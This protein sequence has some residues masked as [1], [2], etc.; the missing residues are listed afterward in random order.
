MQIDKIINNIK[1]LYKN[2][3]EKDFIYQFIESL[4]FYP[5]NTIARLKGD[6]N[7]SNKP[8]ELIWKDKI[9]FVNCKNTETDAHILADELKKDKTISKNKIRFLII[10]NFD[11]F[12]SIDI[13]T[14]QS[15]ECKF[16]ELHKFIDFFLPLIGIEKFS[17][18]EESEADIKA[19]NNL[20]KLYD[21]ILIDN[22][23]FDLKKNRHSLNFFFIRLL[24]LYYADDSKVFQ[25]NLFLK[26]ISDL[27]S[28]DGS[29]LKNFFYNLFDVLKTKESK[30]KSDYFEKFPYVNGF[31]FSADI[32]LPNFT[33]KTREMIISNASLDWQNINPDIFGSMLQ[34][35]VSPEE[36]EGEEMHYTSIPNI[37]KSLD[38]L[39]LNKLKEKVNEANNDNKKLKKI[40]KYIYNL[41]IF[42]PACGSGNFL[43]VAYKN[44]CLI[45]IDI[46]KKLKEIEPDEWLLAMPGIK[47]S[48]F[49]GIEKSHFA[50]ETA[51]LSIW[52]AQHQMNI[53]YKE[54]FDVIK[55][56]LPIND[57][58]NIICANSITYEWK[59]FFLKDPIESKIYILGNPPFKAKSKRNKAQQDDIK[60]YFG[61]TRNI[62]YVAL[63]FLKACDFA[64]Y[65]IETKIGFVATNS[66]NQ[67]EQVELLW[68]GILKRN[69]HIFFAYKSFKW[70][71][72][73]KKNA[74]VTVSIICLSKKKNDQKILVIDEQSFNV[75]NINPYLISAP[76]LIIKKTKQNLFS[77]P[78]MTIGEMPR[79]NGHLLLDLKDK[80]EILTKHPEAEK[81]IK[82]F[83]GGKE[84]INNLKR[85][86][87]WINDKQ[88]KEAENFFLI[89]KR[90]E[91]VKKFRNSSSNLTTVAYANKAYRFVEIRKQEKE[92]FFLP[93]TSSADR[94]YVPVGYAEK[95]IIFSNSIKIIYSPP[96]YIFA[97][98][99]SKMHNVW[100]KN[101]GGKLRNDIRYS[102]EII[103]NNFPVPTIDDNM[104][105][106]LTDL[107]YEL[108]DLRDKFFDKS[109]AFLYNKRSMPDSLKIAHKKI[110]DAVD[111]I[112]SKKTFSHDNERLAS[113]F[114]IY[115]KKTLNRELF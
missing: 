40:L 14:R 15:L 32:K 53:F 99:S 13:K 108:L 61:K 54:V 84:F 38:P 56:S 9:Y 86:C 20:G 21:Q 109:I 45:E 70:K 6:R 103:Y 67:G 31:L 71:N 37:L 24:F 97:I 80:N 57:N 83:V 77:L 17:A 42:D 34:E 68:E 96:I 81:F 29:D 113:L 98:I 110:D 22:K 2:Y 63:W 65:F 101:I 51:K 8:N 60:Y 62:D 75:K 23:N 78:K 73:A 79:D 92:A 41:K 7:L 49:C 104:K 114:D 43:I 85:W 18:I 26:S 100:I 87:I 48:Q 11:L 72:N 39:F 16:F 50:S 28:A 1:T 46:I 107:S 88:K 27:S 76:N 69:F 64:D 102:A 36:R 5:K 25:K 55:P 95:S 44:L 19:S 52:I 94:E 91:Q 82:P 12:L 111:Q 47:L 66:I 105:D 90:I 112:Y 3:S 4:A 59:N 33:K 10:T 30:K 89:K 58:P 106:V 74:T 35:V 93:E 115:S